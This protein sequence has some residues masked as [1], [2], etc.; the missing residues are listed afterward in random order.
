MGTFRNLEEARQYFSTD[1][2]AMENGIVIDEVTE[3]AAVCS[4]KI[5]PH[6]RNA[7]GGVMG[8]AIFT[9]ADLAA[10][11]ASNNRHR[12]TVTQQISM[13]FLD[14]TDGSVLIARARC[15]RDG[16]TTAVYNVDIEDDLGRSIAQCVFTGYKL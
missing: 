15:R 13:N 3:D 12:P 7:I 16:K 6:H 8:G 4:M 14:P 10:G 9:L 2:F 5:T 1:N 11:V